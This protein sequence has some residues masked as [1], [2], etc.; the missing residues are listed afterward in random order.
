MANR[1]GGGGTSLAPTPTLPHHLSRE[2]SKEDIEMAQNLSL[3]NH[4]HERT[5]S[6]LQHQK[7]D[8]QPP[9]KPASDQ[10]SEI[11][12][13]LEDSIPFTRGE[14]PSPPEST[15]SLAHRSASG[16]NAPITGQVC[17]YDD[18]NLLC[19]PSY[20][21][22]PP[23]KPALSFQPTVLPSQ[24]TSNTATVKPREPPYGAD[25]QL[26]KPS[27]MLVACISKQGIRCVR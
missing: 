9:A 5:I 8:E 20:W 1:S 10:G 21:P 27:A 2:P 4:A 14:Q 16:A 6:G 3:L 25:R 13:S 12:H 17:R 23:F 15:V 24:L 26:G 11:Y 7:T 22:H 19:L 18:N